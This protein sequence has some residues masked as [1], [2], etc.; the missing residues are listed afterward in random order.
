MKKEIK[1]SK[2]LLICLVLSLL[3][4]F[5]SVSEAVIDGT[6][7]T[8]FNLTAKQG[9][10]STPDGGSILAWG[11]A[12][13]GGPMQYPGPTLIVNQGDTITVNL[14]NDLTANPVSIMFPGQEDVTATGGTAGLITR[15]SNGPA[16]TVT[17]TFTASHAG[18]YLYESATQPELQVEMGLAGALIVRPAANNQAYNHAD[19]AYDHEYLIFMSEIDPDV[20]FLVETGRKNQIDNAA[21]HPVLW[22]MNGRNF[23]DIMGAANDPLLPHQPYNT[24]PRTHPGDKTLVRVVSTSRDMHP[25]HTHG[26]HFRVIARDGRMLESTSGAGADISYLDYT[27][28]VVPGATFDIL[29]QWTGE[30]LGWDIYGT[31]A[32]HAHTCIDGDGDDFDDTTYEYCPDHGKPIPVILPS[33][34]ELTFGGFYS[35]S[36]YL[37]SAGA[38]PP[39][40]GGLNLNGGMFHIWHSHNER[41]LV[42]NDIFPGGMMTFMIVEPPGVPI[43]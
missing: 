2:G 25:F 14:T 42:N 27:L 36:P 4:G 1:Q 21:Y 12:L 35:G 28:T 33:L 10:I 31:D 40:E 11:Y 30:K 41:E 24:V 19:S 32:A 15:E 22:F 16:D 3:A 29:W 23:P 26:N 34:Q 13:N 5:S 38:L 8:T 37:G 9:Y 17:Y 18:T 7:G 39:G 20:H 6:T 43:P